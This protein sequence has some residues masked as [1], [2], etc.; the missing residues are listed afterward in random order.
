MLTK[1]NKRGGLGHGGNSGG[2]NGGW[3]CGGYN[4]GGFDGHSGSYFY[5]HNGYSTGYDHTYYPDECAVTSVNS[6]R[7]INLIIKTDSGT[8]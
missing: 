7:D 1:N 5:P 3:N 6:P 8:K 4:G 2:Y